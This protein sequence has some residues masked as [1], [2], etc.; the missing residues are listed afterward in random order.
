MLHNKMTFLPGVRTFLT[1]LSFT[2]LASVVQ[3]QTTIVPTDPGPRPVGNAN[4]FCPPTP[5]GIV[6]AKFPTAPPCIDTVQPADTIGDGGAG[7]VVS[8]NSNLTGFWFQSLAVFETKADVG[9]GPQ[10][11]AS[12]F[13][14]LGPSFNAVSCFEC[15]SQPTVGGSS[16]NKKTPGFPNGNPQVADAPTAAQLQAVS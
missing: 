6:S 8:F 12:T 2:I 3:A 4:P 7:N 10:T 5:G 15:H 14:G 1:L 11:G 13:P 16:P 9:P